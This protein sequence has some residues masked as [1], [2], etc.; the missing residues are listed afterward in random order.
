MITIYNMYRNKWY[1]EEE[2]HI[3]KYWLYIHDQ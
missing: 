3:Q 2:Q 1:G